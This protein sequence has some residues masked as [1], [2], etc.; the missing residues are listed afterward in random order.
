VTGKEDGTKGEEAMGRPDFLCSEGSKG[1]LMLRFQGREVGNGVEHSPERER[2]VRWK[3][4]PLIL[5]KSDQRTGAQNRK[6]F[7]IGRWEEDVMKKGSRRPGRGEKK[8]KR[9][10]KDREGQVIAWN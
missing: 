8:I 10:N 6:P 1:G 4:A 9:S 3:V 5:G 2:G 7:C